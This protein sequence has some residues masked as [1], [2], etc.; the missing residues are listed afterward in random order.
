MCDQLLQLGYKAKGTVRDETRCKWIIDNFEERYPGLFEAV[1]VTDMSSPGAFDD[2]LRDA[3]GFSSLRQDCCSDR[4]SLPTQHIFSNTL[5]YGMQHTAHCFASRDVR[6]D[7]PASPVVVADAT[8]RVA[9][10]L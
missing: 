7:G 1:V 3:S 8:D 5:C 9:A 2:L 4:V 10:V 6:T